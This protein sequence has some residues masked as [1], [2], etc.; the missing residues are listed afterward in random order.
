MR[1]PTLCCLVLLASLAAAQTESKTSPAMPAVIPTFDINA[2]DKAA[3][4]C[5]DFFQYACGTWNKNNPLP[6]DHARWGRFD[7]LQEHNQIVLRAILEKGASPDPKRSPIQQKVGDYYSACMDENAAASRDASALAPM[8]KRIDGIKNGKAL[9]AEISN[10]QRQGVSALFAFFPIQDFHDSNMVIAN[11]DQGGLG[12]PDRDYYLKDDP[13]SLIRNQYVAHVQKMLEL[14][15]QK[16]AEASEDAKAVMKIETELA[17]ASMDRTQRRDP[18]NRDHKMSTAD[19]AALAPAFDFPAY[20]SSAHAEIRDGLNVGN[21]DFF[22]QVNRQLTDVPLPQWKTYLHWRVLR[23]TAPML[24][25]PFV[26]EDYQFNEHILRGQKEPRP[27]WKRCVTHTDNDLGEALGELYVE[28]T[29]GAEGKQRTLAMVQALEKALKQ[30]IQTL[31]WMT[32]ATRQQALIKLAAI[33]NKIGYPDKWRDY[34]KL[35][36]TP[37]DAL[38]NSLHANEFEYRRQI[39]KIGKPVDRL[40]WL[41]TP[42]TV[43]AY[44]YPPRN[45]IVFP[46]GIL[47]PPFYSNTADD[48]ANFGGVGSVI[49]HE[50]THGFDDQGRKYD[51]RGELH[52]WWTAEDAKGFEERAGCIAD[53][54]SSFVTVADVKL[55]GRLTLGEN[56]AD[57]GGIRIAYAALM[58]KLAGKDMPLIDGYT[59]QQRFFLTF[60]QLG[61]QNASDEEARRRAIVDPHSPGRWRVNGVLQNNGDF[62]KAFSCK[63]GQPMVSEKA[64]RVW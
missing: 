60:A 6:G 18:H 54:Y 7:E 17:K 12:M 59:P 27:R 20:L 46:A 38:T 28:Q 11:V 34:S 22:K 45:E 58:D 21:P 29:F 32:E 43:N 23:T 14:A 62:A 36:I 52:D 53:E 5:A 35:T 1:T 41:M 50:L 13:K 56:T 19:L 8:M 26:D 25:Q 47:Q 24:S 39:A 37:S 48:A 64:C 10:L 51:A 15:G 55:N 57:N 9:I 33:G 61:C 4:P 3:D 49:G 44:Y 30:D 16:P 40:E 2:I 63:A 31:P 42:P